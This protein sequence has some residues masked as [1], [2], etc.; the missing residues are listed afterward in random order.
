MPR[1][2][3]LDIGGVRHPGVHFAHAVRRCAEI[4]G[5][6]DQQCPQFDLVQPVHKVEAGHGVGA[7]DIALDRV[8]RDQ[9]PC[10][11][12][13]FGAVCTDIFG[14]PAQRHTLDQ[15]IEAFAGDPIDQGR[16][17]RGELACEVRPC[18]GERIGVDPLG[19]AE[20]EG[21]AGHAADRQADEMTAFDSQRVP[22]PDDV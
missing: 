15:G 8:G 14:E 7:G 13:Q 21:L 19:P 6:A 20:R 5:A 2:I 3:D 16:D 17:R 4:L 10:L 22:K 12:H 11:V 9:R 18:V 1:R